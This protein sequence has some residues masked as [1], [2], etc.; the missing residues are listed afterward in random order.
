[1]V[2]IGTDVTVPIIVV[3]FRNCDNPLP[4]LLSVVRVWFAHPPLIESGIIV[5]FMVILPVD[6]EWFLPGTV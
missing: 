4:F 3:P 1:M 5:S 2:P 6:Q